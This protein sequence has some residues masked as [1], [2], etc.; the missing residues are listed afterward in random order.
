MDTSLLKK[1]SLSLLALA[2]ASTPLWSYAQQNAR[3]AAQVV[4]D[5]AEHI[6]YGSG[7]MGMALVVVDNN[8]QVFRSFGETKPGS[9]IRPREDSVVRIASLT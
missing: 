8:Q 5:H 2:F 6:F 3:L 4:D 1:L 7:A 9:D